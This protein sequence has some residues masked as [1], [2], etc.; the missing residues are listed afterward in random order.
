[1]ARAPE[2]EPRK[3]ESLEAAEV[4]LIDDRLWRRVINGLL[5]TAVAVLL[6][7]ALWV[8]QQAWQTLDQVLVPEFDRDAE[9]VARTV[10]SDFERAEALGIPFPQMRGVD[11]FLAD[12]LER[13]SAIVYIAVTGPDGVV[14]YGAGARLEE[15]QAAAVS[16]TLAP[17]E[18]GLSLIHI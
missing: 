9:L 10:A 4:A 16:G 2:N 13:H 15:L 8:S 5:A 17:L 12:Y 7:S 14:A 11:A 6:A 3:P 18:A 1:M